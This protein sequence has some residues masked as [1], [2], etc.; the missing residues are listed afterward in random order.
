MEYCE[1]CGKPLQ[2]TDNFGVCDN[3]DC[4]EK[5]HCKLPPIE[6]FEPIDI[7]QLQT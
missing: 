6:K 1:A 3:F 4:Y 2:E 7:L 5:I